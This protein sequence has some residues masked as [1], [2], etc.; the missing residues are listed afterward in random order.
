[1]TPLAKA[2]RSGDDL[3]PVHSTVAGVADVTPAAIAWAILAGGLETAPSAH[4]TA[5]R[6]RSLALAIT[7]GGRSEY[8]KRCEKLAICSVSRSMGLL[9]RNPRIPTRGMGPRAEG[10]DPIGG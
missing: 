8:V 9:L 4:P 7:G 6:S 10:R 3:W 2:A 1:M 5:S